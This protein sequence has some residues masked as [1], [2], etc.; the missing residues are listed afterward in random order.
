MKKTAIT[1]FKNIEYALAIR[2]PEELNKW[3]SKYLRIHVGHE[4]CERRFDSDL[5][6]KALEFAREKQ[7]KVT[8]VTPFITS[9]NYKKIKETIDIVFSSKNKSRWADEITINDLGMLRYISKN[10]PMLK[11]NG[12]RLLSKQKRGPRI[13]DILPK[14]NDIFLEHIRSAPADSSFLGGFL[15]GMGISRLEFDLPPAGISRP[16]KSLKGTLHYPWCFISATRLC[17]LA[18][19][20]SRKK[21]I[22]LISH[23]NRECDKSA[24]SLT[25]P[26]MPKQLLLDGNGIFT[27]SDPI[28]SDIG[29]Y[30]IDR[31]VF[32]EDWPS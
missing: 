13:L 1:Q 30:G 23:C 10:Y 17:L 16:E 27:R 8:I 2:R 21:N 12:G 4:F 3:Q 14:M 11:I 5:I 25:H 7:V 28:P 29:K 15:E 20:F 9:T 18:Q 19:G 26:S 31:I 6:D 22:R 32:T 24:A